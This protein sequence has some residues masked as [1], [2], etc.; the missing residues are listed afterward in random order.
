[1]AT[2]LDK[3]VRLIAFSGR[4][5]DWR[6]WSIIF[7]AQDDLLGFSPV[8]TGEETSPTKADYLVAKAAEKPD[9][10]QLK[11]IKLYELNRAAFG[12][13]L[14]SI[15]TK[16]EC[17]KTAFATVDNCRTTDFPQ[18]DVK[19]AWQRLKDKFEPKHALL[20]I[21][22]KKRFANSK[23]NVDNDPDDWITLLESLRSDMNNV[24]IEGKTEMSEIDL[25]IHILA[26]CPEKYE[27]PV[28]SLEDRLTNPVNG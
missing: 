6:F 1:M 20:F 27:V 16:I 28:S 17:G 19:L 9:A 14:I 12:I 21:Q 13:L 2:N 22:L 25:I 10:E 5:G 18:G 3:R 26:C 8:V 23:L 4:K 15:Q 7:L 11:S 24:I